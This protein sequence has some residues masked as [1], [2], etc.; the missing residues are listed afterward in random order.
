[1]LEAGDDG[2][3][4][5]RFAAGSLVDRYPFAKLVANRLVNWCSRVLVRDGYNDGGRPHV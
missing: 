5:T 1:V 4:R 2:V 3:A